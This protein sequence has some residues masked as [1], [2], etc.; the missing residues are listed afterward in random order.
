ML[1]I[2]KSCANKF[3]IYS[4]LTSDYPLNN[5]RIYFTSKIRRE[6]KNEVLDKTKSNN[7]KIDVNVIIL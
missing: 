4:G 2:D 7:H 3:F 6:K 1:K 5:T